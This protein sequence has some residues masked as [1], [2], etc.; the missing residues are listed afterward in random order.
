MECT[1][2]LICLLVKND[3][4]SENCAPFF[5]SS[6]KSLPVAVELAGLQTNGRRRVVARVT[7]ALSNGCYVADVGTHV[8]HKAS[9]LATSC[10]L[11]KKTTWALG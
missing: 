9:Q 10:Y 8:L 4:Q 11:Q 1:T 3:G 2:H 7:Q 5:Q 6:G